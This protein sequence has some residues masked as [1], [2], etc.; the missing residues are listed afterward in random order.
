MLFLTKREQ[1]IRNGT[2]ET[3][4]ETQIHKKQVFVQFLGSQEIAEYTC[5][6]EINSQMLK[7]VQEEDF[8]C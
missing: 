2:S 6:T 1:C 3:R 4:C 7:F 5:Q 8:D